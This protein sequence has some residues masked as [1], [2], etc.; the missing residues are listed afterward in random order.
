MGYFA[1]MIYKIG[2]IGFRYYC[3]VLIGEVLSLF[4]MLM[5]LLLMH[6][7]ENPGY[8]RREVLLNI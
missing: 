1:I 8:G 3:D 7:T 5:L 4:P 2:G 6:T